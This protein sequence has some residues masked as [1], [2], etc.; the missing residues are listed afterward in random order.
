MGSGS[1]DLLLTSSLNGGEWSALRPGHF[2]PEKIAPR[3]HWI[4][5]GVGPTAGPME[6]RNT[7][8]LLGIE[9]RPPTRNR[10]LYR[11]E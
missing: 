7:F 2:T 9:P 6:N 11:L 3:T 5:D 4:G 1:I 8:T 10:S